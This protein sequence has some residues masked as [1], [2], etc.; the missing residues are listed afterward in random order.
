[1]PLEIYHAG[2]RA[3]A[4]DNGRDRLPVSLWIEVVKAATEGINQYTG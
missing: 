4:A 1:M 2:R 3:W